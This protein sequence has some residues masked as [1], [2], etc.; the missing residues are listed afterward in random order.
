MSTA[1]PVTARA[2]RRLL[3]SNWSA[4]PVL[5]SDWLTAS[6]RLVTADHWASH[7][8]LLA[9]IPGREYIVQTQS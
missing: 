5:A 8:V 4:R 7:S 2:G 3:A 1:G 6:Q 9:N